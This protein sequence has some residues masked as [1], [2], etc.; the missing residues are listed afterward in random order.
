[1]DA[2]YTGLLRRLH[3]TAVDMLEQR[4]KCV[5]FVKV[6]LVGPR[7]RVRWPMMM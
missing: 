7:F 5:G 4:L 1:M 6:S 2:E 3:V